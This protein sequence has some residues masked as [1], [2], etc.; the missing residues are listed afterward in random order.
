MRHHRF[1]H[2]MWPAIL[3]A[4]GAVAVPATSRAQSDEITPPADEADAAPAGVRRPSPS[5]PLPRRPSRR[6]TEPSTPDT[7]V[8]A[9]EPTRDRRSRHRRQPEDSD[10]DHG[11]D[12]ARRTRRHARASPSRRGEARDVDDRRRRR[13]ARR[14]R[15]SRRCPTAWCGRSRS[16]C[17]VRSSYGN[18][19]GNCRDGCSRRHVGTD[20][21]GVRM[22]PLLAAV[23]GTVTRVRYENSGTAGSRDHRHRRRWVAVQLLPRQQRHAGH[24]R[25]RR[26]PRVADLAAGDARQLG[27][28]RSG[29][30]LHG[31][32]RQ[33]RG[34]GAARALRDPSARRHADEPL[35]QPGRGAGA[36]DVR[37][38]R[39]ADLTHGRRHHALRRCGRRSS[40]S[41]AS[42]AG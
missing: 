13:R 7:T 30:R 12:A 19:W 37:T 24:R 10:D 32:Q 11:G 31:R 41:T 28:R 8:P 42:A 14:R 4:V 15:A 16:P 20:M 38:G 25:R 6:R 33:R 17:S 22:Q 23:D 1:P 29:H 9:P 26:R 18:D 2:L 5:R 3:A 34:F 40:P 21:V 27:S 36:P 35:P 39:G